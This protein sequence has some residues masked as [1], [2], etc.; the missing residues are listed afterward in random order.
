[1]PAGYNFQIKLSRQLREALQ[2]EA[3]KRGSGPRS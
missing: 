1:M 3:S 2:N